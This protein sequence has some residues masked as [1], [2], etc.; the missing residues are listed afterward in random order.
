[1][2]IPILMIF[3]ANPHKKP[4]ILPQIMKI[5]RL[6]IGLSF[7]WLIPIESIKYK[8][9]LNTTIVKYHYLCQPNISSQI[10]MP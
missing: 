8:F 2:L 1:M 10:T 6:Q 4:F 5:L 9:L 3:L 7:I